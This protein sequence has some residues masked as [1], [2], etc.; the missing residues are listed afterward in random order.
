LAIWGH[1]KTTPK[2]GIHRHQT[3]VSQRR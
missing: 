3:P 2:Q 1:I